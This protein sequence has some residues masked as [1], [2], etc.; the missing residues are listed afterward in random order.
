MGRPL[1]PDVKAL[2]A[3]LSALEPLGGAARIRVLE[4]VASRELGEPGF[5][6]DA[7][8]KNV[9]LLE[10]LRWLRRD[11]TD[12]FGSAYRRETALNEVE[13]MF[14]EAGMDL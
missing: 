5:D 9:R 2:R 14:R 10:G 7:D 4:Y 6:L 1:E 11:L 3:I 13:R 8:R 12:G